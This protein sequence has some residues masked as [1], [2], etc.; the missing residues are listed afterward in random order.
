M[1]FSTVS[2][3]L[4]T[5]HDLDEQDLF[6]VLTQLAD[7]HI[8]YGDL[9]FQSSFHEAWVLEDKIIKNGSYNIDQG[10]GIRA[11]SGEKTGFAYADQISLTALQQSASAARSIVREQGNG[12]VQSLHRVNNTALY[13]ALDPLRAMPREEKIAL[14]HR[15]DRVARAEDPRVQEVNASLTG[16]YEEVLV[17]ATDGTLATDI[18][19]LVRLSVSVLVEEDG[20]REHGGSGG[21]GRFGYEYFL[22]TEDGEIRADHFAREAV[23]M[24]LVNLSAVAA[25]AGSM[26]VVLG[27]GWPGVLLHEAVGHGLEGDF[28]RR[29]ASVF[30]GK[31]GQQVT[32]SL[33]T[34]VDDG[35]IGDRR[36]SL[37]I[38][39]EGVPGQYN[40]LIENGILKGYMQ[41]KLNARLMGVDPTGNGRRESYAHLP[42]PR[43]TNTYMLAGES[44][45]EE[46]IAS[47]KNGLYAPNF[48]GGQVDITSGKFVFSTS[49]AYLIE[50][51]KI[52]RPVK[53]ATLIGSGIEAMQQVSMVGNDLKL[54]KGVGVCGKEGQSVPVGVG[55]P[56]L[57]LD[58]ITVGGTA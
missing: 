14:L 54:D 22:G 58:S 24:A 26:P 38:D 19:P 46:I 31:I 50:D 34:I 56:T 36:G 47:V 35:T 5:A 20:K 37:A 41:D 16:V 9:Y 48:G 42:M 53:G 18:R 40:V 3:H 11:V 4:L 30:S 15:L 43:M 6:S 57:K 10:V 25:P 44:S 29:G 49:E 39:D 32:S 7:R 1:S 52:T 17:A 2:N 12:K 28:N 45:P 33:C 8:D 23:R 55:Q 13:A 27:A 21:G 51:G